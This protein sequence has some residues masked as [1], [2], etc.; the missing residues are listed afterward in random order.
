MKWEETDEE[1]TE[2]EGWSCFGLVCVLWL[3]CLDFSNVLMLI[4]SSLFLSPSLEAPLFLNHFVIVFVTS[5]AHVL[6]NV[7]VKVDVGQ[8]IHIGQKYKQ[9]QTIQDNRQKQGKT[10]P[11]RTS[12][13]LRDEPQC[14][15]PEKKTIQ[16]R[17]NKDEIK[18]KTHIN[19]ARHETT[20]GNTKRQDW[21]DK[22]QNKNKKR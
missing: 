3:S 22:R 14:T 2:E 7:F 19:T 6:V 4:T 8:C 1:E 18:H 16:T 9:V 17:P 5:F 13:D 20:Q 21:Q 15:Q 12:N 11:G 10:R